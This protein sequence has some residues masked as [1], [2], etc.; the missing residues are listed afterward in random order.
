MFILCEIFL[1]LHKHFEERVESVPPPFPS[2][3]PRS[4]SIPLLLDELAGRR[5]CPE[6]AL[7]L[8]LVPAGG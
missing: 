2:G 6:L 5:D 8:G 7:S 4:Q 3:L 1:W